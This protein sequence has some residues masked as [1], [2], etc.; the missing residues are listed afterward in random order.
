MHLNPVPPP[1]RGLVRQRAQGGAGVYNGTDS[2][3]D[4]VTDVCDPAA[5]NIGGD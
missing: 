5:M 1:R 3:A 2:A 4:A